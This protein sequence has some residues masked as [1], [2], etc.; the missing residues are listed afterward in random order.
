MFHRI[1]IVRNSHLLRI[2]HLMGQNLCSVKNRFVK[3]RSVKIVGDLPWRLRQEETLFWANK[4][5]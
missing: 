1:L 4:Q 5:S 3:I 2:N